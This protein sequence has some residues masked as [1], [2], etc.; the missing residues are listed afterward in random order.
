M[1]TGNNIINIEFDAP[2]L[3]NT[4]RIKLSSGFHLCCEASKYLCDHWGY[5][6]APIAKKFIKMDFEKR[7]IS[8]SISRSDCGLQSNH[9]LLRPEWLAYAWENA[10]VKKNFGA[11]LYGTDKFKLPAPVWR[12]KLQW[13]SFNQ[14]AGCDWE[15]KMMSS[16]P[17]N[18]KY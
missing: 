10:P 8:V 2:F 9:I 5:K 18:R 6:W 16:P 7:L 1:T 4:N 15:T 13:E 14:L 11:L 3:L 12:C 17:K